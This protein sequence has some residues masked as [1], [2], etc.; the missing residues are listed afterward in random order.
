M[1]VHATLAVPAARNSAFFTRVYIQY[2][3]LYQFT[4]NSAIIARQ[5]KKFNTLRTWNCL[6]SAT[7]RNSMPFVGCSNGQWYF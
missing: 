6:S 2:N 3:T 5:L 7:Q 1:D 4:E